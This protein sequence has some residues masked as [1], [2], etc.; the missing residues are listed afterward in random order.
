M[1]ET[2]DAWLDELASGVDDAQASEQFQAW[3]DVQSRFHDYSLNNTLLIYAQMPD[4]TRVAGY[5]TWR[6]EFDRHVQE[7]E[8]AIW[9]WAPITTAKCPECGNS[10][11]Y[12]DSIDCEYDDTSPEEWS[13]G[14]VA[15][16]PVPVFDVSQTEGEPLPE[17]DT[18]T[19][20]DPGDLLERV[21]AVAV[22]RGLSFDVVPSEEWMHGEAA[23]VYQ[24][25]L[26]AIEV[27]E[28]SND[29][30]EAR[31][32]V[33]ELAH[34]VLHEPGLEEDERP[35][36]ELEAEATAYVVARHHGLDAENS[37]FYLAAWADQDDEDV[38]ERLDR[39]QSTATSLIER[40]DDA[41]ESHR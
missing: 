30:D 11:S 24:H 26:E 18:T 9:I 32:A 22:E 13:S 8:S 4:A 12:H 16:K 39:I 1:H 38:R 40:L 34:A 33:H 6:E 17:L 35:R 25:D 3:L 20:G 37:R 15:F 29:A 28:Q 19:H 2:I 23:G 5:N 10:P 27:E 41:L 14:V 7:G 21:R 36:R 31:V